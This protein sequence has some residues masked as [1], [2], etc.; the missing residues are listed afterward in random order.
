[1][2]AQ[3]LTLLDGA[4]SEPNHTT[5]LPPGGVGGPV[6]AGGRGSSGCGGHLVVVAA[7]NRPN[8]IDPALRCEQ[9]CIHASAHD[10]MTTCTHKY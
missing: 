2:V 8:A 1:M 10:D 3:L 5:D 7:S 9:A 4:D 6:H